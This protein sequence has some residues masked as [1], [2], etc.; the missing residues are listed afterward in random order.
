MQRDSIKSNQTKKKKI[1][2][3]IK[4]ESKGISNEVKKKRGEQR[5]ATQSNANEGE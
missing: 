4:G 3:G 1:K 5:G 2:K